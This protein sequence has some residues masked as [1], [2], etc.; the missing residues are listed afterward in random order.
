MVGYALDGSD[1]VATGGGDSPLGNM[2]STAMWQ[3]LGI[4]TDFSLTNTTGIRTDLVPGPVT[5]EE[6]YNIFPFDNTITKMD[7]SGTEVQEL[8]NFVALRS[9]GRGCVSQVQ[10]A[11]A[12]VVMDCTKIGPFDESQGQ[13]GVATNIYIGT[14]VPPIKCIADA[15]CPKPPEMPCKSDTDCPGQYA[16][17]CETKHGVCNI[18]QQDQ[19][20]QVQ[21]VC[22]QPIDPTASYELA[23]SNYLA[24]GGSGFL[25]LKHNTTQNNTG[26]EQRDALIDFMR[27]GLPCGADTTTGKLKT[28]SYDSECGDGFVCA[29]PQAVDDKIIQCVTKKEGC[30]EKGECVLQQCRDDVATFVRQ[31]C[32]A[33]PTGSV[34]SQ[35]ETSL[36][37][38]V[39]GGETC[40][41]LACV[42]QNLGNY[43]DNR[44]LM[45]GQ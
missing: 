11:G 5:I 15:D 3:R 38:C 45:V 32:Q 35:C 8:F 25:V 17:A 24:G 29:C 14:F 33:A 9:A 27:A 1:R 37:P 7:L 28:C 16:G 2:I 13:P 30:S 31:T 4:Q 21:H 23:T 12:R 39:A 26:V 42:N 10:I 20:D 6:M 19:C 43:S 41:Y 44:V 40:K 36:S 22:F 18:T 34:E